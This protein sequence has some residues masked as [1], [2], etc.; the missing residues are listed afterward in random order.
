MSL[1]MAYAQKMVSGMVI[2]S[3]TGEKLPFVNVIYTNG[4]GTQTDFNGH[5]TLPFKVG[6]LRFSVI[7]YETKTINLKSAGDSLVFKID[8][9][10]KLG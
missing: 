1:S 2:D 3:K 6:K 9:M 7:G 10:E 8:P 4:G 5:F